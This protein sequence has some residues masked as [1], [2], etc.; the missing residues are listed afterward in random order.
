MTATTAHR[1]NRRLCSAFLMVAAC[2][3]GSARIGA[4]GT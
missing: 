1:S 4:T 3:L 2:Q